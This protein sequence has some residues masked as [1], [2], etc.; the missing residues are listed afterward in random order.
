MRAW[1]VRV[2]RVPRVVLGVAAL[3]A[4]SATTVAANTCGT[5]A[6]CLPPFDPNDPT[7]IECFA[8]CTEADFREA[9]HALNVCNVG[10]TVR[11]QGPSCT[12]GIENPTVIDMR[13]ENAVCASG[14]CEGGVR[15][16]APCGN[17]GHCRVASCGPTSPGVGNAVCLYGNGIVIDGEHKILFN[18]VPPNTGDPLDGGC[19]SGACGAEQHRSALFSFA[20]RMGEDTHDNAVMN[21]AMQ[22]FP[23]GIHVRNGQNHRVSGVTNRRICEDAITIDRPQTGGD[24]QENEVAN[25]RIEHNTLVGMQP[26]DG[27]RQ[28]YKETTPNTFV[29]GQLCGLDKAIQVWGG[30]SMIENNVID[31]IPAPVLVKF[32]EHTIRGNSTWGLLPGCDPYSG[33]DTGSCVDNAPDPPYDVDVAGTRDCDDAC[34]A[35]EVSGGY[36]DF[37]HNTVAYCKFG[38]KTMGDPAFGPV[39]MATADDNVMLYN[40]VSSFLVQ[41]G[42]SLTAGR[43][44][45]VNSGCFTGSQAERGA[46]VIAPDSLASLYSTNTFCQDATLPDIH[47]DGGFVEVIGACWGNEPSPAVDARPANADTHIV[48]PHSCA[49][50][51]FVPCGCPAVPVS[52]CRQGTRAESS[53][54]RIS[55]FAADPK[56]QKLQWR[57]KYGDATSGADFGDPLAAPPQAASN[58]QVCIY[59]SP[60]DRPQRLVYDGTAA[61]GS[62]CGG[63]SCW[64]PTY[65]SDSTLRKLRYKDSRL[66]NGGLREI[67]LFPGPTA[68]SK[69]DVVGRGASLALPSLDLAGQV[70][71]QLRNTVPWTCWEARFSTPIVSDPTR[72]SADSDAPTP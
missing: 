21:F 50:A 14:Q 15:A 22:Y 59:D 63:Q 55:K 67:R 71:A 47:N 30:T 49:E 41:D 5:T 12:G 25:I 62:T 44:R 52:G 72:Y 6:A 11:F 20:P 28:C 40:A 60:P 18:Y 56:K 51:G 32:G 10:R 43:N 37:D 69:L 17:T 35:Y 42:A 1:G 70:V 61:A 53:S 39:A 8:D 58:Y 64:T 2:F 38:L 66:E 16:G 13:Q 26:P 23:E 31:T 27:G 33:P 65:A 24:P 48:T 19:C 9:V 46:V 3:L 54:L 45:I 29:G 4:A 36:V 57:W 34:Q 68:R 7:K